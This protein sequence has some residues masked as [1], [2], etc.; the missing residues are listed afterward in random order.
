MSWFKHSPRIKEPTKLH[1]HRTTS[2]ILEEIKKKAEE[3]GPEKK[4]K[5][6]GKPKK[7]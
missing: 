2:P 5:K 7:E 3:A 4:P 1:A 6:L